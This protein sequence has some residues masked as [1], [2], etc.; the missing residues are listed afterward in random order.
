M[1]EAI[2]RAIHNPLLDSVS[3]RGAR[4]I[5]V[6][7]THGDEFRT[8]EMQEIMERIHDQVISG[9]GADPH[10][11]FGMVYEPEWKDRIQV[12]LIATGVRERSGSPEEEEEMEEEFV[13]EKQLYLPAW[14]RNRRSSFL[15]RFAEPEGGEEPL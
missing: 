2:S 1:E 14:R 10:I 8:E 12:T 6:N 13:D 4:T 7:I 11:M 15:R 9:T 3:L 5:L